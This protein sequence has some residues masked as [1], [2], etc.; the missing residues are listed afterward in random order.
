M[1]TALRILF[2]LVCSVLVLQFAYAADLSNTGLVIVGNSLNKDVS[3]NEEIIRQRFIE[4]Q[5]ELKKKKLSLPIYTYHV[6]VLNERNFCS[7]NLGITYKDVLFAGVVSLKKVGKIATPVKMLY[8]CKKIQDPD[9]AADEISGKIS[10]LLKPVKPAVSA[11]PDVPAIPAVTPTPATQNAISLPLLI[12]SSDGHF[13]VLKNGMIY[14]FDQGSPSL[15]NI[16][17]YGSVSAMASAGEKIFLAVN[18]TV[19]VSEGNYT[20]KY[21]TF[22]EGNIKALAAN[23]EK[24][25]AAIGNSVL[26]S[27]GASAGTYYTFGEGAITSISPGD[28]R[29]VFAAIGNSVFWT[30]GESAGTYYTFSEGNIKIICSQG[31][32]VYVLIG[33]I[34]LSTDGTTGTGIKDLGNRLVESLGTDGSKV[35]FGSG[36]SVYFIEDDQVKQ[37]GTIEQ[38]D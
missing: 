30:D 18:N 27:D 20:K 9:S 28:G 17:K 37:L 31:V 23:N 32:K 36:K 26:W 3:Q 38:P 10:A 16:L 13:Y 19:Y 5:K 1:K 7:K 11:A 6:N 24:V 2:F 25:F 33:S 22:S 35:Y 4:L 15:R 29:R 34:I 21:Y 12:A 8:S 14:N